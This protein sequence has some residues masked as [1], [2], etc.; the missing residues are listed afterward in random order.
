M[1]KAML[2]L[3]GGRAFILNLLHFPK[4]PLLNENVAIRCVSSESPGSYV[5]WAFDE[6]SMEFDYHFDYMSFIEE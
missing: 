6:L 2:K 1:L 3:I 5:W 4:R